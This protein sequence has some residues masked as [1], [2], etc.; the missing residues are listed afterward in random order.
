MQDSLDLSGVHVQAGLGPDE[1]IGAG[2]FPF[3]GPLRLE[4]LRDLFG[5]PAPGQEPLMLRRG[6]TGDTDG[7]V[8]LG[9]GFGLKQERDH[10]DCERTA[11]R[12]P[13]LDLSAPEHPDGG[14]EDSFKPAAMRGVSKHTAGQ[15]IA[16]QAAIRADDPGAEDGHNLR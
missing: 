10:D 13:G 15:F 11:L 6:G 14:M 3:S 5:G 9:F 8:Q 4:A 7:R 16:S 2:H 12:A 1:E